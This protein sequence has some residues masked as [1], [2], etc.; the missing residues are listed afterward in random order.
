MEDFIR[1]SFEASIAAKREVAEKFS[2][3]IAQM[4]R[5]MVEALRKG[6]RIYIAGNGGSASDAQHIA[7]ELVGRFTME[8]KAIPAIALTADTAVMTAIANDYGYDEVFRRQVEAHVR[9][10]DVLLCISTS[11]NSP[12]VL[13]ALEQA[14]K[15][16]ARVLALSGRDGGKLAKAAE[17][18][19][20]VPAKESARIQESHITIGHILCEIIEKEMFGESK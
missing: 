16:G 10:G 6:R 14:K 15:I 12:N 20:T 9:E 4:A 3:T 7:G 17:L 11:G 5:V 2:S 8:R 19:V 18:C 1:K 13:K